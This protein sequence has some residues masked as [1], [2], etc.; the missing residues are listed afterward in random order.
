MARNCNPVTA[1]KSYHCFFHLN[2]I[3]RAFSPRSQWY[4][5]KSI[6]CHFLQSMRRHFSPVKTF[7]LPSWFTTVSFDSFSRRSQRSRTCDFKGENF[8]FYSHFFFFSIYFLSL[9]VSFVC[10]LKKWYRFIFFSFYYQSLRSR[11]WVKAWI[12][13]VEVRK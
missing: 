11:A 10:F 8:V 7:C 5:P 6:T 4:C 9:P 13:T 12:S 1:K 2:N 3:S